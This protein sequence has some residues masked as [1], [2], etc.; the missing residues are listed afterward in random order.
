MKVVIPNAE[1][2]I[3]S[4][5]HILGLRYS[6]AFD[7]Q[8]DALIEKARGKRITQI[9]AELKLPM[10][11]RSSGPRS[12]NSRIWGNCTD[13]ADQLGD[14]TPEEVKAAMQ[15]M[16]VAEG[17]P[18]KMSI[19]GREVPMPTRN[20]SMEEAKILL[21]V[22]QRFADEH[23]LYLTEYDE[24]GPYQTVGGRSRKEMEVYWNEQGRAKKV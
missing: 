2:I 16:A 22:I 6:P 12:Q 24:I 21:D 14:Y 15:R 7:P 9:Y 5:P 19:D 23:G 13:I 11:P 18:T 3:P 4:K 17:Y 1:F 20:A 8:V 10:R